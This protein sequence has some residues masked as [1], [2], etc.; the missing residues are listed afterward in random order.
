MT[1]VRKPVDDVLVL[2]D[3]RPPI[4]TDVRR[5]VATE[6]D[7]TFLVEA[8][9]GTG[10]TRVL[11]DRYIACLSG[12]D[13]PP[14]SA[15]VAIT[16][17]EKAAGELR[18]RIRG[19]LERMLSVGAPSAP[20]R[21]RLS[22]ALSGL[23][24][25]PISTIHA[26]A[27]RLLRERPV[28]AG[29]DPSFVQLDQVASELLRERLWR[30]W[31]SG[32]LDTDRP[33]GGNGAAGANGGNGEPSDGGNGEPSDGGNREPDGGDESGLGNGRGT[34]AL[35]AEILRAGV[36]IEQVV[37]LAHRR[38]AERCAIDACEPPAAPDLRASIATVQIEAASVADAAQECDDD[39]DRLKRGSLD[40]AAEAVALPVSGDLHELGRALTIAARRA[41]GLTPKNAGK[42]ANWPLGKE[43][44]LAARDALRERLCAAAEA[45][46]A[47]VA[48]LALAVAADFARTAAAA[49]LDAGALDFDDLLG[50]ARDLLAG[51]PGADP[52]H[53][54][55]VRGY[56]Q[57]RY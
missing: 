38:F 9:A 4:D 7:T 14:T 29:V 13:A 21:E 42:A 18:Q 5:R 3:E 17:T 54:A 41:R 6:L 50:R 15:V 45:Y 30:D 55:A 51:A 27:A 48:G 33:A 40:L 20:L 26:F 32:L 52:A 49:Q 28:E 2:A 19:R 8:G 56:F 16:F 44:M 12:A 25:A 57:R 22:L 46:G 10:K 53:V 39:A 23:D 1:D 24:D 35:L 31:L 11:V 47:Y 34:A 37:Q 36:S 43:L